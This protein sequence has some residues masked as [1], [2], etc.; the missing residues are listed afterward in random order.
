MRGHGERNVK[1]VAHLVPNHN[2]FPPVYPAGTELRVAEVSRRQSHYR[3]VV[4]CGG[5]PGQP[6]FERDGAMQIERIHVGR[7]YRRL[8]QKITRIDPWPYAKRLWQ[9]IQSVRPS[10]IHIH[11]E[12]KLLV[13]L[14]PY[15]SNR[16]MT[17]IVHIANDKPI[18]RELL[19]LVTRWVACSRYMAEWLHTE[20]G[21]DRQKIEVIYT[22][23]DIP[24]RPSMWS[25]KP[26]D[27]TKIRA[28]WGIN[29]NEVTF[30]FA[31][32]LV[33]EKGVIEMLDAFEHLRAKGYSARLLV[34]GNVRDSMDPK[35]EKANY[36]RTVT[37]R[38][39]VMSHVKWVGSLHPVD[40]HNFLLA[41]DVFMLPSIWDD[42]F[43]TSMVEA[44]CAGL[45]IIAGRRGGVTE[46]LDGC[47][48]VPLLENPAD[49]VALANAMI[50]LADNPGLRE[51]Q[52]RCLRALVEERYAWERVA[53][54]FETLY[55]RLSL[56]SE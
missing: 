24:K 17:V 56:P 18:R 54:E 33:K 41:G 52:G 48:S 45:P 22:G 51:T 4:I 19:P 15:L 9:R 25:L 39:A 47:P 29:Q 38:M 21:V 55:D 36:G 40:V 7:V 44:A 14:A 42:P 16:P 49:P 28:H 53:A 35:N 43:P 26:D 27:R 37:Q 3:P 30:L 20:Y 12:P 46:F 34:A 8:F 6:E 23:V 10:L 50:V 13:M 2:P 31:G 1:T 5:F 11:N 32:R